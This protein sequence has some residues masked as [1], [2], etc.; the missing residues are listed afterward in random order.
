MAD[1]AQQ[2]TEQGA[3][4]L[5]ALNAENLKVRNCRSSFLCPLM[6]ALVNN[7][8]VK[9]LSLEVDGL[10]DVECTSIC[11]LLET[12]TS[13]RV[14]EL[15]SSAPM[16]EPWQN[17]EVL[18]RSVANSKLKRFSVGLLRSSTLVECLADIIPSLRI[19]ELHFTVSPIARF[20]LE[21]GNVLRAIKRNFYLQSVDG[22]IRLGTSET[23]RAHMMYYQ[24]QGG[25]FQ[26]EGDQRRL[27]FYLDRNQKL[28]RWADNI[29]DNRDH[30]QLGDDLLPLA[31]GVA[32]NAERDILYTSLQSHL[33]NF[34]SRKMLAKE[35][36]TVT[37]KESPSQPKRKRTG[38][39]ESSP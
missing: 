10:N 21:R 24:Y 14:F 31:L 23:L 9:N 3:L 4:S 15:G 32:A 26:D 18:L 35:L 1:P 7:T 20:H 34:M 33:G 12:T 22:T 27:A 8:K 28:H 29:A 2:V 38:V 39:G 25:I 19:R 30:V 11:Q 16:R 5:A 6:R 13:L 37:N 36:A 17:F